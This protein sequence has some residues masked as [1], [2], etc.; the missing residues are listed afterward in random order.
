MKTRK[1]FPSE[2]DYKKYVQSSEFLFNYSWEGKSKEQIILDM[3][4]SEMEQSVLDHALETFERY[5]TEFNRNLPKIAY[6]L[7]KLI[8]QKL[9]EQEVDEE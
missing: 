5:N 2:D 7:D 4:L 1:D 6:E 9:E 8:T 3:A